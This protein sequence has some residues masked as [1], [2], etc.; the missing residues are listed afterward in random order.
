MNKGRSPNY[1]QLT[2]QD[3]IEKIRQVYV[4]EHTHKADKEVVA[5]TLGYN[6]MNGKSLMLMG[7]LKRYGL[8]EV[9]GDGFKVSDDAVTILELTPTEPEYVEAL[10]RAAYASPLFAELRETYGDNLPSDVNLRHYL[11]KKKFLPKAA[12]DVIRIYRA[13]LELVTQQSKQYNDSTM[14][15]T[16]LQT[17]KTSPPEAFMPPRN[18]RYHKL[19]ADQMIFN[20]GVEFRDLD[21][22]NQELKFRISSDSEATIIFKGE[23]TQKAIKKLV[24]LLNLSLDTFPAGAF[25]EDEQPKTIQPSLLSEAAPETETE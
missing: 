5:K 21:N 11:I 19:T 6:G 10:D 2:L 16:T 20:D 12:D 1:P 25:V 22:T 13:N 17:T 9:E 18:L 15:D 8:L 23:V 14:E 4:A 7:T 3:A 24:G